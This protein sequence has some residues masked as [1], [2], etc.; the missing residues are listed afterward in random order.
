MPEGVAR[1]ENKKSPGGIRRQSHLGSP[2]T[3]AS[4]FDAAA[5]LL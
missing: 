5:G 4:V 1:R 2:V 3:T